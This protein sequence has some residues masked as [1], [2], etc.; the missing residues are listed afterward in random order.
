MC[1]SDLPKPGVQIT[2]TRVIEGLPPETV[3]TGV[4]VPPG[5]TEKTWP[6]LPATDT[7]G[8]PYTYTI[9]NDQPVSNY[10]NPNENGMEIVY[11]YVPPVISLTGQK[12]WIKGQMLRAPI[13][14]ALFRSVGDGMATQVPAGELQTV[15]GV[16]DRKSVV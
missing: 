4:A 3:E 15:T 14:L 1:S 16:A 10:P 6:N 9:H 13:E 5:T 7:Y 12:T 8:R 11:R 2:L